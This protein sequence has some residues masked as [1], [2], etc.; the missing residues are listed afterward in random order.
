MQENRLISE[1]RN[2][3]KNAPF[4][5]WFLGLTVGILITA[6]LAI[7]YL[8]PGIYCF[9]SHSLYIFTVHDMMCAFCSKPEHCCTIL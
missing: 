8:A 4:S 3:Y 5:T 7:D 6:I 1:A 2:N 9:V